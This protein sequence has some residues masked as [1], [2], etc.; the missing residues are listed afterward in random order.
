MAVSN[1]CCSFIYSHYGMTLLFQ[2]C[3]S[4]SFLSRIF[5]KVWRSVFGICISCNGAVRN[6][7]LYVLQCCVYLHYIP[8]MLLNRMPVDMS[9]IAS[10]NWL[11]IAS[12]CIS[13]GVGVR[14]SCHVPPQLLQ[15]AVWFCVQ[16]SDAVVSGHSLSWYPTSESLRACWCDSAPDTKYEW[17]VFTVPAIKNREVT[18][19]MGY[20]Y[21]CEKV[22]WCFV[23]V[24]SHWLSWCGVPMLWCFIGYSPTFISDLI[25]HSWN[26]LSRKVSKYGEELY[27]GV[28]NF[29]QD[30]GDL[31]HS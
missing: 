17:S 24:R 13:F 18:H 20:Y 31:V 4:R 11:E 19:V 16:A 30:S 22:L 14:L 8:V 29:V 25:A 27:I 26:V 5:R 12:S 23:R 2:L 21:Y 1:F 6:R 7:Y 9:R 15:K 10:R 28:Q 3:I